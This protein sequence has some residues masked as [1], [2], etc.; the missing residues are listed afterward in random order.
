MQNKRIE[1]VVD[2]GGTVVVL[3]MAEGR[4]G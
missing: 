2:T 3:R 1:R 4:L